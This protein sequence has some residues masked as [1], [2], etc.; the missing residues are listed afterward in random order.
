MCCC[1][2][3]MNPFL[4]SASLSV[5]IPRPVRALNQ[6][7]V[8]TLSTRLIHSGRDDPNIG[9]A[10]FA[11]PLPTFGRGQ[12]PMWFHV[13]RSCRDTARAWEEAIEGSSGLKIELGSCFVRGRGWLTPQDSALPLVVTLFFRTPNPYYTWKSPRIYVT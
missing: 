1:D 4:Q 6:A 3:L 9:V 11:Q 7:E 13:Q 5:G 8:V 12:Q 2:D 10:F